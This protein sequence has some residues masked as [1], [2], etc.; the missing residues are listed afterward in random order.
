VVCAPVYSRHDSVS[1]QVLAGVAEGLK[2]ESS[3]HRDE[4]I[5]VPKSLLAN[6]A[7]SLKPS[8]LLELDK[9]LA[10][11]VGLEDPETMRFLN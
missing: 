11:A 7:G 10:V 6:Y 8:V 1:T 3:I 9:A 2:K 5:S 4:L